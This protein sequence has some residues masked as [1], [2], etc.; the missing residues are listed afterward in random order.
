METL[1]VYTSKEIKDIE[2]IAISEFGIPDSVLM[3]H[4]ALSVYNFLRHKYRDRRVFIFPGPGKNGGDALAL[5]RLLYSRNWTVTIYTEKHNYLPTFS[6]ISEI[7]SNDIVIDGLFGTGLNREISGDYG[8]TIKAINQLGSTII[9]LDV[10]SGISPENGSIIGKLAVR[11]DYT[12]TFCGDKTGLFNE[13]AST[14]CGEIIASQ[15]SIPKDVFQRVKSRIYI[16]SAP[17]LPKKDR[18]AYKT[19]YGRILVIAGSK[20]YFGAPLFSAKASIVSGSGYTTLISTE[21]V[22]RSVGSSLPEVIYRTEESLNK[23]LKKSDFIIYGPGLGDNRDIFPLKKILKNEEKQILID[24]DGLLELIP[25]RA[26]FY[27]YKGFKVITPHPGEASRLLNCPVDYIN[28]NRIEAA[29]KLTE[30]YN[31]EVVLKGIYSVISLTDGTIYINKSGSQTLATAGSGD[32]LTGI[33]GGFSRYGD[34]REAIRGGV[35]IHSLMGEIAE[36]RF[37]TTIL[38][39]SEL[40]ECLRE[41]T[42][43]DQP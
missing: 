15:L 4:A 12:I 6:D 8:E 19:T 13:P 28:S 1:K 41:A 7:N 14:N 43:S 36:K 2:N 23:E 37:K 17:W 26:L 18:N 3:E 24:G 22:V 27:K 31:T 10:P 38:G 20:N 29:R 39:A 42:L 5:G 30:L 32:I 35:Y 33:I 25:N 16:N 21:E 34:F 11:A 40:L 9:S